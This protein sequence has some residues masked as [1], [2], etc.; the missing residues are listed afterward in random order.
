MNNHSAKKQN[1][2]HSAPRHGLVKNKTK[3]HSF[4]AW[5]L[6]TPSQNENM[7][8]CG[9]QD[10]I[11]VPWVLQVG[12][13]AHQQA[14]Q[15]YC[16]GFLLSSSITDNKIEF[17]YWVEFTTRMFF[18]FNSFWY[19][20]WVFPRNWIQLLRASTSTKVD[21]GEMFTQLGILARRVRGF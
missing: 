10:S 9:L 1:H 17:F 18:S 14:S 21:Q 12:G 4:N 7:I 5:K 6:L 11:T 2:K 3:T 15:L 19:E 8:S 20:K 16:D 13:R